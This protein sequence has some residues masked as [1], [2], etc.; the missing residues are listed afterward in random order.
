MKLSYNDEKHQYWL[1]QGA[2]KKRCKS[3]T[4]LAKIPDDEFHLTAWKLRMVAI[5]L[6]KKPDL[7]ESVGAHFSEKGKLDKL[8]T[9]AMEAA[10]AGEA[11]ERGTTI[12]RVAERIAKGEE[13]IQ[14]ATSLKIAA[15]WQ[16]ALTDAKLTVIPEFTERCIVYPERLLCG[17]FDCIL[18]RADGTLVTA[19]V[20]TGQNAIAFPHSIAIQLALYANAPLVAA[21]FEG[22]DGEVEEFFELP[23]E[24][25]RKVG[26]II[27]LPD[28]DKP[29]QLHEINIVAGQK[30]VN[31]VIWPT[32][33]WRARRDLT[34]PLR[35]A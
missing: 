20:K 8:C 12:H 21:P 30:M 7:L 6:A 13:L 5:G 27:H 14:T 34:R 31:E 29:A 17:K 19:D 2:S 11:A 22:L 23:K 18:G 26:L 3:V 25:D 35:V 15:N 33:S 24:L 4:A 9:Q 28:V 10:G 1:T 16:Q 32:L